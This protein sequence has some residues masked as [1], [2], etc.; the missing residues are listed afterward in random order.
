MNK[1]NGRGGSGYWK[2]R[3]RRYQQHTLKAGAKA[4]IEGMMKT[5]ERKSGDARE[6][7]A[8]AAAA[9]PR[10]V[11]WHQK[12]MSRQNFLEDATLGRGAMPLLPLLLLL[13]LLMM[14]LTMI[15]L[16]MATEVLLVPPIQE[17]HARGTPFVARAK[18]KAAV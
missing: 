3:S 1:Q 4:A 10:A 17:V 9:A 2:Q 18:Q 14:M 5:A 6:S 12:M 11:V 8:A 15:T 16:M 7:A 13:L